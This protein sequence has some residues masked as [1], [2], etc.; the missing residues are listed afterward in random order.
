ME[1]RAVKGDPDEEVTVSLPKGWTD[2]HG[3]GPDGHVYLTEAGGGA[4]AVYPDAS[5]TVYETDARVDADALEPE[6][7]ER[8]VVACYVLG[9]GRIEVVSEDGLSDEQIL[10]V[11]SAEK[12]LMGAGVVEENKNSVVVRCSVNPGEFS[13]SELLERLNSTAKTMRGEAVEAL[14]SGD[15]TTAKRAA[16]RERQANKVFVLVLRLLLTAQQNPRVTESIGLETPLRVVGTRASA[17]A[18]ERTADCAEEAA[19]CAQTLA[20]NLWKPD[21]ETSET[22][23]ALLYRVDDACSLAL[24]S[25]QEGDIGASAEARA[26]YEEA[27]SIE[28]R[29]TESLLQDVEDTES[30]MTFMKMVSALTESAK[31]AVEIAEVA[32]NRAVEG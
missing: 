4:V 26:A 28:D 14:L 2:E 3:V 24:K 7:I 5:D 22:L 11:Y 8:Y 10:E 31:E 29:T 32:S 27:K 17:K 30:V 6:E 15:A 20:Q 25:L 19:E 23:E 16:R 1:P 18:L 13:I 21:D 9:R 12:C